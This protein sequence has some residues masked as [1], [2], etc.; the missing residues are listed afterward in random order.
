VPVRT[1]E[2]IYNIV[3]E[4]LGIDHIGISMCV[5]KAHQPYLI[6]LPFDFDSEGELYKSWSDARKLYNKL[7][8]LNYTTAITFSGNKG[9]HVY[10]K[11]VPKVYPKKQIRHIQSTFRENY[12]L[13][14]MDPKLFGDIRR[15]LRIPDTYN[16]T[17]GRLCKFISS[18]EGKDLD[19]DDLVDP[20]SI[21]S[22]NGDNSSE[23]DDLKFKTYPCVEFLI[24]DKDYWYKNHHK[25]RFEPAQPIR[26]SWAILRWYDGYS[27]DE[28]VEEAETYDWEDWDEYKCR[29]QVEQIAGQGDY[30]P[31]G[32]EALRQMGYCII[33]DCEYLRGN[34]DKILKEVGIK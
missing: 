20:D 24:K 21:I 7:V 27:I 13:D 16:M 22:T 8:K 23:E 19:L 33:K 17:S 1:K 34:G 5:Y 11:T 15:L 30:K 26:F 25:G 29:Y 4:H 32:C 31:H 2:E 14:T 18:H 12:N 28:I 6:F 3:N 9:F 10:V